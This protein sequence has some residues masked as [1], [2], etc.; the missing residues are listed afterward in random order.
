MHI[1]GKKQ[2]RENLKKEKSWREKSEGKTMSRK[3][4]GADRWWHEEFQ[5]PLQERSLRG[6]N[7]SRKR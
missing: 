4:E 3:G 7:R 2:V 5:H 6:F 1:K